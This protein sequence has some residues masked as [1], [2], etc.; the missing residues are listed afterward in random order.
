LM[1][2]IGVAASLLGAWFTAWLIIIGGIFGL[3][4]KL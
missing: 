2:L 3:L 1:I 4:S